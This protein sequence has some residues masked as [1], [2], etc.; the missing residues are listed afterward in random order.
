MRYI[1]FNQKAWFFKWE[2]C[3]EFKQRSG[4]YGD[5]ETETVVIKRFH[6][7]VDALEYSEWIE[8]FPIKH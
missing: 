3:E 2:L 5:V 4:K 6:T 1:R 7:K 8:S